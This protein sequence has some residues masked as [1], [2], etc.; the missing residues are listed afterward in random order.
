[1]LATFWWGAVPSHNVD[2]ARRIHERDHRCIGGTRLGP[3]HWLGALH[4]PLGEERKG[5]HSE[6]CCKDQTEDKREQ[7]SRVLRT[8]ALMAYGPDVEAEAE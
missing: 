7:Q 6:L 8:L 1:M 4:L 2:L 3:R 5:F